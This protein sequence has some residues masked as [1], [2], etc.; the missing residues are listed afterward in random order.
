MKGHLKRGERTALVV[1]LE[2][3]FSSFHL[4]FGFLFIRSRVSKRILPTKLRI[5]NPVLAEVRLVLSMA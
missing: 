3:P 1:S 4:R 5:L 2:S